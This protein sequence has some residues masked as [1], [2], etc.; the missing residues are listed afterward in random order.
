MSPILGEVRGWK[1]WLAIIVV[2]ILGVIVA[3]I[4]WAL[5]FREV[6]F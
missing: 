1:R 3:T 5:G 4:L 6:D 2:V